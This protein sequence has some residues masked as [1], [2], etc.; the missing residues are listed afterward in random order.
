MDNAKI[1]INFLTKESEITKRLRNR[2]SAIVPP[3]SYFVRKIGEREFMVCDV[4]EC[5]SFD[6]IV[7]STVYQFPPYGSISNRIEAYVGTL[8]RKTI[9]S[10]S[11]RILTD[12]TEDNNIFDINSF[13][14]EICPKSEPDSL[15]KDRC[16]SI[17]KSIKGFFEY[18]AES[19]NSIF[20]RVDLGAVDDFIMCNGIAQPDNRDSNKEIETLEKTEKIG[21]Q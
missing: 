1:I 11:L 14:F 21:Y 18:I 15:Y 12:L 20:Q 6:I 5:I 9:C 3:H 10:P 7:N 2:S 8:D 13:R 19:I 17:K 4:A 16:D